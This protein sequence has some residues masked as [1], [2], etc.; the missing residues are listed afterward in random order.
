MNVVV[1]DEEWEVLCEQG[2]KVTHSPVWKE[3]NWKLKMRY[4]KTP[5]VTS[6]YEK[7]NSNLCWRNCKRIGDHTH[8]FW[9]CPILIPFWQGIQAEIQSI[10]KIKLPLNPLHYILG[11]TP[12]EDIEKRKVQLLQI[13]LLVARKLI[14]LPR[15]STSHP[16][17]MARGTKESL[18]N[19][20]DNCK[21]SC[22]NGL[23]FG[24]VGLHHLPLWV[25]RQM[26]C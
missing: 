26:N 20:E 17:T 9:D 15:A 1:E 24:F 10:L 23:V 21:T 7:N 4:F 14:T 8:I 6:K 5:S 16:S 11:L 19:G 3:F 25:A 2:H 12:R 13:L 22:E 18:C